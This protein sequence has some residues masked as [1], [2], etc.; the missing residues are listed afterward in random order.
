MSG[1][2]HF[3]ES[4]ALMERLTSGLKRRWHEVVFLVGSPLS[5]PLSLNSPGVP[6]VDGIV[7]LI[8]S[9]F[10]DEPAQS[11][12]LEENLAGA[13]EN[14]YN[15]AFLFL[16]GRRGQQTANELVRN[17]VCA[18]RLPCATFTIVPGQSTSDDTWRAMDLISQ[19]G[20]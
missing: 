12:A 13:A 1:S 3:H 10:A 5:A 2:L 18:A 8:R 17:A 7:D 19:A 4:H 15:A 9:E 11:A 16:L 20:L 14:R 6:D